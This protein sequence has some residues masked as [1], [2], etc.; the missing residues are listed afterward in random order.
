MGLI[1][2]IDGR[3]TYLDANIFIYLFEAPAAY[4]ATL[5]ALVHALDAGMLDAVTSELSLA[6]VLVKPMREAPAYV[7]IYRQ[8]LHSRPHFDVL[9]VTRTLLIEAARLRATT[10]L[11]LPDAIHAATALEARCGV[12]LTNDGRLKRLPGLDIL[13]LADAGA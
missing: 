6:E 3:R 2:A 5:G 13:Q 10:R 1:E 4:Q 7:P 11:K 8:Y 12:L 9:P